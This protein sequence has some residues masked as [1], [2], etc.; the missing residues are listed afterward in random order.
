MIFFMV[1]QYYLWYWYDTICDHLVSNV[2]PNHN[3]QRKVLHTIIKVP[4]LHCVMQVQ[5]NGV[6]WCRREE[7]ILD[8]YHH[9]SHPSCCEQYNSETAGREQIL[10]QQKE[11]TNRWVH[12][13]VYTYM[14]SSHIT[15]ASVL[16]F[17]LLIQVLFVPSYL[18]MR[19]VHEQI[20]SDH[21]N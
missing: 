13:F 11:W 18:F 1:I 8:V 16:F 6:A 10:S 15:I 20:L 19:T 3:S 2:I 14:F 21:S 4:D 9:H 5:F 12:F 7:T 17:S